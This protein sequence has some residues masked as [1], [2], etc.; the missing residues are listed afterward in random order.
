MYSW[1]FCMWVMSKSVLVAFLYVGLCGL[2]NCSFLA[3][4]LIGIYLFLSHFRNRVH[5]VGSYNIFYE[6]W[7]ICCRDY[8][9]G[10]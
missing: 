2:I 4:I 7:R 3:S 1:L 5:R 10:I 6:L 9:I 8:L